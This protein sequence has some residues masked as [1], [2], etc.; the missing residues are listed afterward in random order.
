LIETG[1]APEFWTAKMATR[2]TIKKATQKEIFIVL[3]SFPCD[4]K[5]TWQGM[6]K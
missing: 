1:G 5:K 3:D 4:E 2:M 6:E